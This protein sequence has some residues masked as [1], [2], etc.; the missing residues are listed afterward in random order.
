MGR[1]VGTDFATS[2][3][4]VEHPP[5]G[6]VT[7]PTVLIRKHGGNYSDDLVKMHLGEA[8][9]LAHCLA[10][11]PS[12]APHA[13]AIRA[14]MRHRRIMALEVAFARAELAAVRDIAAQLG[15]GPLAP[16]VRLKAAVAALPAPLNGWLA[17]VL[18]AAGTL[19]SRLSAGRARP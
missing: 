13:P 19:K 3:R 8:S 10:R 1:T 5:I 9:I 18:L 6:F 12:L 15:P 2:L 16:G 4:E 7:V 17:R 14:S 11:R